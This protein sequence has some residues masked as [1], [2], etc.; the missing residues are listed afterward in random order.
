[1]KGK[2]K[3]CI[4]ALVVAFAMLTFSMT[5]AAAPTDSAILLD[6]YNRGALGVEGSGGAYNSPNSKGITI[7]WIQWAK[8]VPTIENNALKLQ[9]DAQGWFGEGGMIKDP[10][11]KYIIIKVKGEKGGEEKALS[12]NPDAKGSVNFVDLKG[13]D[14]KPVPAITTDYQAIVIDIAASGFKLPD[15]LEAIH[16][17]NTEAVT[18]YIDEIYLSKDGKPA[19]FSTADKPAEEKPVAETPQEEKPSEDKP[20]EEKPSAGDTKNQTEDSK[21]VNSAPVVE[22]TESKDSKAILAGT[23]AGVTLLAIGGVVYV[24]Y[25]RKPN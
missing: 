2:K 1:M 15:G 14:G 6:D 3:R 22:I 18:I 16:F 9:M 17:N 24:L 25:I 11:F 7:Y 5:V 19:D 23:I 8:A 20:A 12:I 4:F 10:A 13:A 21:P